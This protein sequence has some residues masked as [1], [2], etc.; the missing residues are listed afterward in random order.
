M[1]GETSDDQPAR[2]PGWRSKPV[3]VLASVLIGAL[4]VAALFY[5]APLQEVWHQIERMSPGW[6]A[7]AVIFE[8]ASCL[9]Y[10]ILFRR[11]FPEPPQGVGRQVAWMAMGAGA[12][13]PGGNISSA[14]ATGVLLR[15]HGIGLRPLV[16]RCAA[17][18]C[19][20]TAFGFLVNGAAGVLLLLGVPGGPHD[21]SHA[22]VPILV[23]VVTLSGAWLTVVWA[24]R[25]GPGAPKALRGIAEGMQGA[26]ASLR[27]PHWRL[28]GGAGFFL[29]D[30]GALWAACAATGHHL[31]ALAVIIAYCIGYLATTIPMP[32]GLGVLDSGLAAA[33]VLYGM[34]PA[35]SVGAVLVYHAISIWVPGAGG[36]LAWLPTRLGA[37]ARARR[38]AEGAVTAGGVSGVGAATAGTVSGLPAVPVARGYALADADD[39]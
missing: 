22:G 9:S 10:V 12:V 1:A 19:L 3:R 32:A 13:L 29:L 36:L 27:E 33:L 28:V 37:L 4:S 25:L 23:S 11:V 7:A 8:L 17:L 35:A 2:P 6:V 31:G 14:A 39:R 16:A 21:I 30:I 38:A 34:K 5:V 18:L 20:L 26:W 24:R 15:N